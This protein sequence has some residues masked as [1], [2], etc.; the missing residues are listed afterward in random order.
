MKTVKAKC[1]HVTSGLL[2][3]IGADI[4]DDP[5][6]PEGN[7]SGFVL[8]Y[9]DI[10]LRGQDP[11]TSPSLTLTSSYVRESVTDKLSLSSYQDHVAI[12]ADTLQKNKSDHSGMD[13]EKSVVFMFS[14]RPK[15]LNWQY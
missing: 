10:P 11:F 15:M 1:E 7:I 5:E 2:R 6:A 3:S 8:S 4:D 9:T 12:L 14:L 13:L